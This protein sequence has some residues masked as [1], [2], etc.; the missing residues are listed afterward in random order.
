ML[1][2]RYLPYLF[3]LFVML[4]LLFFYTAYN[5]QSKS[6]ELELL[7]QVLSFED[8]DKSLRELNK[9]AA[10][11]SI[12]LI[13]V[14]FILGPLSRLWPKTFSPFL[15]FRK[16]VGI[17][18]F[19]LGLLHGVY[20]SIRFYGL[21]LNT[22]FFE[23]PKILAVV[24]GLLGLFIFFLMASTSTQKAVEKMG[25]KRWKALQTSGYL[26]LFLVIIHFFVIESKP[27]IGFDVRPFGLIFLFVPILALFVRILIIFIK[28][29]EKRK[30]HHHFGKEQ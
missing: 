5:K 15:Y 7:L 25:Y 3:S 9:I 24:T 19:I 22:M 26:A 27:D 17:I 13:T 18:G 23:N 16:P 10:L 12:G 1:P 2:R 8:S 11:G 6:I 30:Y 4:L 21:D 28:T 20:S 29:K 14:S